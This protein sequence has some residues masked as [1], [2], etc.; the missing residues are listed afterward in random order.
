MSFPRACLARVRNPETN[1]WTG[2][3]IGILRAAA[4]RENDKPG[5]F[6]DQ[7]RHYD[8]QASIELPHCDHLLQY[9]RDHAAVLR[10]T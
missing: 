8:M 9:R 1:V 5:I 4:T 10:A 2:K 6:Q 3:K 7:N